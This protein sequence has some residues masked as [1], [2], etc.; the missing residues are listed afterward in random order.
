MK[1]IKK[2][3]A[4]GSEFGA[5]L[6]DRRLFLYAAAGT[7]NI[8]MSIVPVI[9]IFVSLIRFLPVTADEINAQLSALLPEQVMTIVQRVISGIYTDGKAAFT[10][11]LVVT[12]WSASLAMR[13]IMNGLD[14]AY[15]CV[16]EPQNIIVFYAR[17]VIYMLLFVVILVVSFIIMAQGGGIID[18]VLQLIP[19][20]Q[21]F[22]RQ[23]EVLKYLRY[24]VIM[25]LLFA[26]FLVMYARIPK[27]KSPVKQQWPGALFSAA[28]WVLFSAVFSIYISISGDYGAYGVI[29]TVMVAM[30]WLYYS[31]FFLLIGGWRNSFV[32]IK[33]NEKLQ[34]AEEDAQNI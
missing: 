29:G 7:Y 3:V 20:L 12:V 2:L 25:V 17:S 33:R 4:L 1:K 31:I 21:Q 34:P 10:I 32:D 8:F 6:S 5:G 24:V 27:K 9:I 30:M 16:D 19:E 23:F 13:Q 15:N 14:A 22:A 11:S 26:V 28:A 18:L